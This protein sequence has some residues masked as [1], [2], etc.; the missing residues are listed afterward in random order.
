LRRYSRKLFYTVEEKRRVSPA[1]SKARFS[2]EAHHR[3]VAGRCLE[4][5]DLIHLT[6]DNDHD[7]GDFREESP[8]TIIVSII[9]DDGIVLAA[10]S[11]ETYSRGVHIK[12]LGFE[13]I[14]PLIESEAAKVVMA[15]SGEGPFISLAA[16]ILESKLQTSLSLGSP[17]DIAD[18]AED[19][20][21]DINRR[22]VIERA[23]RLGTK[24][25]TVHEPSLSLMLGICWKGFAGK[26]EYSVFTVFPDGIAQRETGYSSLG[27]GSAYA[28]YLLARMYR[29]HIPLDQAVKVACY[30]IEQVKEVEPNCGGPTYVTIIKENGVQKQ[31]REQIDKVISEMGDSDK[32]VKVLWRL[33]IGDFTAMSDMQQIIATKQTA[34]DANAAS[35]PPAAGQK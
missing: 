35:M 19:A 16:E 13:K 4:T 30:V 25:D 23:S 22:Y 29:D 10:D 9:T 34:L 1:Q 17:R 11:Q 32:I 6:Q 31:S 14:Y 33:V 26:V 3:G 20:L 24:A 2:V 8:M 12:R 28:E 15:G 21:T 27:S 7:V 5:N 18:M